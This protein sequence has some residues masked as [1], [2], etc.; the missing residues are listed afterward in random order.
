MTLF[1]LAI[2]NIRRNVKDYAVYIGSMVFSIMIYFTFV[3]LKYS[4]D[5]ASITDMKKQVQGIMNASSIILIIF[6]AIFITYSNSFF[7]KKRKKEMGL[8]SLLGVRKK[9]IG[10]L[11]F[12]E[13][14]IIGLISLV[15]GII[16]GFLLSKGLMTILVKLMGYN[17]I[18]GFTL[19]VD[20]VMNTVIVF[21]IIF[22]FTSL[23]G[24]RVIYRFKLIELF[25]AAKKG[26]DTPKAKGIT[27]VIGILFI[28][29]GYYL[30]AVDIFTSKAWSTIGF[31]TTPVLVILLTVVGTYLLF[32]SVTV[33]V[34]HFMKKREGWAWKGLNLMTASQLLY[35]IRGNAKTLTIIAVLSAT[36]IT[37]GG[38][39]FGLYYN[40]DKDTQESLPNTF[41]WKGE[42]VKF[43]EADVVYKE[44]LHSKEIE[45]E[46]Q[47][48][49]SYNLMPVSEYNHIAKLQG[50]DEVSIKEGQIIVVN[51]YYDE[52]FSN[53]EQKDSLLVDR[54]E[55]KIA[56]V[57]RT[58]VFNT[59]TIFSGA[60]VTDA[61]YESLNVEQNVFQVV[62]LAQEKDQVAISD[63]IRKQLDDE[64]NFSSFP[65]SYN[66][67][68]QS[69]GIL[70]FVGSFLGLVFLAATGSIIYFKMITEAEEDKVKYEILH[71]IGVSEKEMTKTI[72]HQVGFIFIVPLIVGLA[73]GAFALKAFS[74]LFMMNITTPVIYWMIAYSIIYAVYYVL[75]V[76]YFKKIIK[77]SFVKESL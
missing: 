30:S 20:A 52:I 41:M 59:Y 68:I 14:L 63:S 5:I 37:A 33:Y 73:H 16:V 17:D 71:K 26:E 49:M 28:A 77:Q 38:A 57:V 36:T 1:D 50:K 24:Y 53:G 19:S 35:R 32:H 21:I 72:R 58:P 18:A 23:Q 48:T 31:L 6:V 51:S 22:L 2:K 27:V 54:A 65:E 29:A 10:F 42:M 45:I 3:T 56:E 15:A 4:D 55:L 25:H 34:L 74:T 75:T 43:D 9:Q 67:S 64:A 47:Y 70:L 66:E 69:L 7:M 8:Y 61:F 76:K 40:T 12:F 46:D 11:L 62:E 60:V 13:N 39:V 44:Q